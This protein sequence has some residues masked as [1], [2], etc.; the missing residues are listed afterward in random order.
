MSQNW[1]ST[2]SCSALNVHHSYPCLQ[3]T[4]SFWRTNQRIISQRHCSCTA[5]TMYPSWLRRFVLQRRLRILTLRLTV[6]KLP[7][8]VYAAADA[9]AIL[10]LLMHKIGITVAAQ[11]MSEGRAL[12]QDW[13][14]LFTASYNR[15][16]STPL[17]SAEQASRSRTPLS[18][19]FHK[20]Y[21]AN[22]PFLQIAALC[23]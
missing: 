11:G 19:P 22:S 21:T 4:D 1:G 5:L 13:L 10:L 17:S 15:H 9:E 12:L 20:Y 16:L 18:T 23:S 7:A 6:A 2:L 8:Q 3:E 14:V